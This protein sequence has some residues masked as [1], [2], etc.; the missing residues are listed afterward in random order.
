MEPEV[1]APDTPRAVD[2]DWANDQV[3][4]L[5]R[6]ATAAM[7]A[8]FAAAA[9]SDDPRPV[10][11]TMLSVIDATP[12]VTSSE[13]GAALGIK[14]ANVAPLVAELADEGLVERR[15]SLVDRRRIGLHVTDAGRDAMRHG[16]RLVA[17][18]EARM[19]SPL[20]PAELAT[21]RD[22]LGRIVDRFDQDRHAG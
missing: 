10:L 9:A 14:R 19:V 8:D 13:L 5:L 2:T 20:S 18:H 11:V 4:Y 22:L 1:D 3:G 21:L 12:D 17:D 15:R 7:A 6:R 16:Q